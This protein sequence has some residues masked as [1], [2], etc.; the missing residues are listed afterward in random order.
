[1]QR[2]RFYLTIY[3]R[4]VAMQLRAQL[5]YSASFILDFTGTALTLVTTFLSLTL[6]IGRF[7]TVGGWTL[8]EVA[9]LYGSVEIAFGAAQMIFAG[10]EPDVFGQRVRLGTFDQLLLRPVNIVV[11]VLGDDFSLRRLGRMAQGA[12]VYIFALSLAG[13]A[14]TPAKIAYAPLILLGLIAFIAALFIFGATVAFWTID[15]IEVVNVLTFGTG[16][17]MSYPMHIYPA[18]IRRFFTYIVPAMFL[19]YYPA[20]YLLDKPDPFGF[21][22]V[23]RFLAPLVGFAMLALM[24]AVWHLGLR[25][26]HSTGS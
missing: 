17:T 24:L 25:R 21:H 23:M 11:Q 20:L 3:A 2:L 7:G 6:I 13:I 15:S 12:G 22:P 10:F 4:L 26:Y 16:D 18:I 5:Q 9:F 1:M 19:N 14:W 8:G